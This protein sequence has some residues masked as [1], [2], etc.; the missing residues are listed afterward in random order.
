MLLRSAFCPAPH[1]DQRRYKIPMYHIVLK[2]L[3]QIQF[4]CVI[5]ALNSSQPPKPV[6]R[7]KSRKI[8]T[9]LSM[10]KKKQGN[11]HSIGDDLACLPLPLV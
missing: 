7:V 4:I 3:A 5:R 1:I 10:I 6:G 9:L 11:I 2:T 8:K